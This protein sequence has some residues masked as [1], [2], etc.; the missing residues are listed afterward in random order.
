MKHLKKDHEEVKKELKNLT[1]E[2]E[3]LRAKMA[4]NS[5]RASSPLTWKLSHD[6][7]FDFHGQVFSETL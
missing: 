5:H 6:I 1:K 2:F 7:L 4:D 3:S